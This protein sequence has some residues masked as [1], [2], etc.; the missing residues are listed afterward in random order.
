MLKILNKLG[1]KTQFDGNDLIINS[2]E[3]TSCHLDDNLT[4]GLRTSVLMLG[5]LMGRCKTAKLNYPGGCEIGKR[6]IDIHLDSLK[7]LGVSVCDDGKE[8]FC[9][10]DRLIGKEI[11]LSFPSVG[12]TENL[13]LA[14]VKAEGITKIHNYAKE[15]EILDLI[16]ML[17]SMGARIACS[18]LCVTI[19]GVKELHGTKYLP[20]SDRIEAGTFL[21]AGALTGGEIELINAKPQNILP[22]IGKFCES[23]CKIIL[24]NDIIYLKFIRGLKAFDVTTGPYPLFPTDLQAPIS[25]LASVSK[26]KSTICE[27][28]FEN[29]FGHIEELNKMGAKIRVDGDTA[30]IIGVSRLH[31]ERV[32]AKDLR[33]GAALVLAGL[34]AE[35]QTEVVD[36]KHVERGYYN[37]DKKLSMLG[38]DIVKVKE[39]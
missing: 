11:S 37:F 23:T 20:L 21:L 3:L 12:A 25:V 19:E 8:I 35:G 5:A 31:G 2:K 15:P 34:N 33:G 1:V 18:N 16:K 22:L 17:N 13:I 14:S 28:I 30:T 6:P 36:V 10:A 29:R 7:E 39:L 32:I 24:K 26:G 9:Y 38:I 4:R 27:R